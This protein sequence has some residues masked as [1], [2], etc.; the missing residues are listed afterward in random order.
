MAEAP[1]EQRL[2]AALAPMFKPNWPGAT[3]I[4][5]RD[6]KPVFRKAYGLAN[7]PANA[8]MQPE[9]QLRM[10]SITKQFTA[11]GILMLAEQGKLS[12]KDDIRKHLPDFPDKG[13][14]ITIEHLLSTPPASRT[15]LR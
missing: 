14:T 8:A 6:G 13:K 15:T 2:D 9:M 11:V 5:T 10:G 1:L 3:V 4:V 7:V 12:V